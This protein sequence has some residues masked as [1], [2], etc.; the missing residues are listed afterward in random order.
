MDFR[1]IA[2]GVAFCLMWSSAFTSARVIVESA[3]PLA[4]LSVRFAIAG[5]LGLALAA[6]LGKTGPVSARQWRGIAIFGLCQNALYLGFN[7]VAMQW[8]EASFAAIVASTLPLL[9]ALAG[10]TLLGERPRTLA[11][12]GLL[13]GFI[14]VATIM[15]ARLQGG[16]DPLGTL[17]CIIG[18]VA[19]TV[20]TMAVR[21]ASSSGHVLQIV[22]L[23]MLVGA[24]ALMV[25]ALMFETWTFTPS[26]PLAIAFSYT[27]IVPGLIATW[28]WF[29]LVARIG[30]VRA[31]TF[32]FLNPFFG[33]AIAAVLLSEPVTALDFLGVAII[34]AGILA[35]QLSKQSR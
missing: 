15:G 16:I 13:A 5:V 28:I 1:A 25:P 9:V 27:V 19:L 17:F 18:V 7:F 14:G 23:Q 34:A 24:A 20:A 11:I 4:A 21:T 35:V 26:W 32:H 33:V 30:M 31:A 6:A 12:A 2:M 10:W 29:L 22:S 8:V 3:P